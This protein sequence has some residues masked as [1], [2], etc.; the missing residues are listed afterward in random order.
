MA[1]TYYK[2]FDYRL[3][4]RDMKYKVGET[5]LIPDD[6]KMG[7]PDIRV[8]YSGLHCCNRLWAVYYYYP[9]SATTRICVVKP[10]GI[11][12]YRNMYGYRKLACSL[13]EIV[14]ELAYEEVL[15]QLG[16]E[17]KVYEDKGM[18]SIG[19]QISRTVDQLKDLHEEREQRLRQYRMNFGVRVRKR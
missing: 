10:G 12:R 9:V 7:F 16:K 17:R 19:M 14:R 1:V 8:C 2:A 4:C 5:Y 6:P 15:G 11:V 3:K 18:P 13:L